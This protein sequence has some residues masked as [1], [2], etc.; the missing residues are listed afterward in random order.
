MEVAGS[1]RLGQ[2]T[3]R[4]GT[5][6]G[7]RPPMT[8]STGDPTPRGRRLVR[9]AILGAT[10]LLGLATATG[11]ASAS[12]ASAAT[13]ASGHA[14]T[15]KVRGAA[16]AAP[17]AASNLTYHGGPI[18]A[19][20]AVYLVFWGSQWSSDANGVQ[21]YVTSF[22]S[23]LGQSNDAWSRV[24]TQYTGTNGRPAFSGSVL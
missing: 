9:I 19:S 24:T 5:P 16:A 4:L 6:P 20:P 11:V 12:T 23:G 15:L 21:S 10:A 13:T 1:P 22:F 17:F 3:P 2:S 8:R 18:Q 7:R 14:G